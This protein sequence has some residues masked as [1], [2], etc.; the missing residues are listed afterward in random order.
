MNKSEKNPAHPCAT[1]FFQYRYPPFAD[2]FEIQQPFKSQA[3]TLILQRALAL[4]RQGKSLAIYGDAGAGKSMLIKS[5]TRELD[6]KAYRIATIPYGGLKPSAILRELC[7]AFGIDLAGRKNLLPRLQKNFQ[8]HTDKP[9]PVLIVDDAHLMDKQSFIDICSLLHDAQSRTSAAALILV[10]QPVLKK[11]LELD[12][13]AAVRTRLAWTSRM[14]KLT[15]DET[16]DFISFRLQISE[17]S[18]NLFH[19]DALDCIAADAGGN[20]RTIMNLATLCMEEAAR[21][22]EKVITADIVNTIVMEQAA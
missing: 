22:Q 21:R 18:P 20:R 4:I 8:P 19:D 14:Q 16:K 17:A 13:F 2:T 10:G 6:T 11:M 3:E 9:F 12:I 7:E 5:I 15:L 1:E